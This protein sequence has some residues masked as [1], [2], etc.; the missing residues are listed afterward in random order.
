M[1]KEEDSVT[2]LIDDKLKVIVELQK[3]PLVIQSTV[4]NG[5]ELFNEETQ[6]ENQNDQICSSSSSS[7]QNT[8]QNSTKSQNVN[9]AETALE[10]NKRELAQLTDSINCLSTTE[11]RVTDVIQS[12]VN[13]INQNQPSVLYLIRP[14]PRLVD[15]LLTFLSE[16]LIKKTCEV[17][18][19]NYIYF[20]NWKFIILIYFF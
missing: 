6:T 11:E 8:K 2:E 10:K 1:K 4:E 3:T 20:R 5:G 17:F 14:L 12:E 19:Y 16:D 13:D 9:S 7:Y 18:I 15:K